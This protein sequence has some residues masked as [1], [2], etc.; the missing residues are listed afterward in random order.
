MPSYNSQQAFF[1]LVRAGLWEQDVCLL[2]FGEVDYKEVM[3]L[4]E[5]QSVV[6]LVTAG[7]EHIVDTK[8]P[9]AITL[10]FIGNALK[11]EERNKAM[12]HFVASLLGKMQ[13][14]GIRAVLVKG[15]GVAQCYERPLWRASGDVDFLLDAENYDK[16]KSLL[17]SLATHVET[18]DQRI[19]HQGLEFDPWTVELHGTMWTELSYRINRGINEA[20]HKVFDDGGT[21][22]WNNEGVEVLLPN[23]KSDIIL[24]FTHF[25]NHFYGSGIGLRQV[26]DWCRLLWKFHESIDVV[27]L[28]SQ[29]LSMGILAEWQVFAAFAVE[30]LGMPKEFMPFYIESSKMRRRASKLANWMLRSGKRRHEQ[31]LS[32]RAKHSKL[33]ANCI[34]F[35]HRLYEFANIATIFPKNALCFFV[36]YVVVR[37][38]AT[39]L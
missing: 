38:K 5:V 18:E 27:L 16:A 25:L 9:K 8:A 12:N 2:P 17:S 30:Y 14:A 37:F 7:M 19:L 31:D 1:A 11:I 13:E 36:H 29:L 24:V 20:Q 23:P 33:A 15:Q 4:A 28:K 22:V 32:Y 26:C 34:T 21:R 3:R 10:V 6:G 35:G 39:M